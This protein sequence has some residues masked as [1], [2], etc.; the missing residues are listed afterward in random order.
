MV[1]HDFDVV[2]GAIPPAEADSP[3]VVHANTVLAHPIAFEFFKP[4]PRRH[5][6]VRDLFRRV[7][8]AELAQH[9]PMELRRKAPDGFAAEEPFGIAI[10]KTVDHCR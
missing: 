5:P 3:L 2:R 9:E 7:D 4:I 8:E 6:Q 1:I 10:G